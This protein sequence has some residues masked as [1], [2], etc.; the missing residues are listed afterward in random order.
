MCFIYLDMCM[1]FLLDI[2]F[3]YLRLSKQTNKWSLL[4]LFNKF[5]FSVYVKAIM[6]RLGESEENNSG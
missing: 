1:L 3:F 6:I 5:L 2:G 4:L